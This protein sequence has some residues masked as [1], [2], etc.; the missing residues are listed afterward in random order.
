MSTDLDFC[1]MRDD[2]DRQRERARKFRAVAELLAQ[3]LEAEGHWVSR[4]APVVVLRQC[5]AALKSWREVK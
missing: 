1:R 3:A 4:D 2:R 5:N